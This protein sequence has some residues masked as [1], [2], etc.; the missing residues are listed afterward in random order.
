MSGMTLYDEDG[1]GV[2]MRPIIINLSRIPVIKKD[3][4]AMMVV[5]LDV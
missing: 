2:M 1:N 5:E 4:T 3:R